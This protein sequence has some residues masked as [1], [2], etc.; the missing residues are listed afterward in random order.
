[1]KKNRGFTLVELIV[2]L[3][4][5]AILAAILTPALLGYIDKAREKEDIEKAK[6]CL[7]AAQGAFSQAY[8]KGVNTTNENVLGLDA[9]YVKGDYKDV[10]AS[11]SDAGKFVRDVTGED[12]YIFL[13]ATGSCKDNV[14]AT[15]HQMYTIYYACYVKEKG[16]RPYY[17][18]NGAW[19][20]INPTADN[21]QSIIYKDTGKKSNKLLSMNMYIQYYVLC[22][23]DKKVL[24]NS[25]GG[26]AN[27][28]VYIKTTLH[29]K[30]K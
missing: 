14:K 4:I 29:N 26:D 16:S 28:W 21:N 15:D 6:A 12:P 8:G 3:V 5:L 20:T 10:E 25:K 19:T 11:D 27:L 1:M 9:D 22:N 13:V 24:D 17:Y 23:K 2:V 18:Y 7:D 30:Y